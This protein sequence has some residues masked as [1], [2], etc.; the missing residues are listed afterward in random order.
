MGRVPRKVGEVVVSVTG[1]FLG[2]NIAVVENEPQGSALAAYYPCNVKQE[3]F[4]MTID[5]VAETGR[6][7]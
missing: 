4:W 2:W 5:D 7:P 1:K 3:R 6:A